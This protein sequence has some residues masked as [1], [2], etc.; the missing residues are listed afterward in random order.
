MSCSEDN[1]CKI[2]FD[3]ISAQSRIANATFHQDHHSEQSSEVHPI[4]T[5]VR[6]STQYLTTQE[7][8][9]NSVT[10]SRQTVPALNQTGLAELHEYMFSPANLCRCIT[11][12][13]KCQIEQKVEKNEI[14]S[15]IT[16]NLFLALYIALMLLSLA[17]N[18]ITFVLI[19]SD[20]KKFLRKMFRKNSP[21]RSSTSSSH[22]HN[23]RGH[24]HNQSTRVKAAKSS[25]IASLNNI[26]DLLMVNLL[27]SNLIITL[28]VLPNQIYLFYTN[29]HLIK[30][31][32]RI[33]EFLKAFSVSLSI[34][35]LVSISFQRLIVIK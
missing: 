7:N 21:N 9:L 14:S 17:I 31:D 28:Y 32:C 1:F 16:K 30:N 27:I 6:A 18:L 35:S 11:L 4:T 10:T 12:S 22:H 24:S 5:T 34:Y 19:V 33:D 26:S 3:E 2:L 8:R 15:D 13:Y 23:N 25:Q 20:H 29:S